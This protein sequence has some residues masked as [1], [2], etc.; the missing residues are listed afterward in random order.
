VKKNIVFWIGVKSTDSNLL[1]KHGNFEYLQYSKYT[2]KYWCD[3]HDIIFFEYSQP[4]DNDTDK[5]RVTWQRWFDVFA[6]VES[7]N[8]EYNKIAVVDGSS[9]IKWDTPNFFNLCSDN[10]VAFRSLENLRWIHEGVQGYKQLFNDFNFDITK[11]ISCG[12]QIFDSSHKEFLLD[13]KKFYYDNLDEILNL[14]KVVARGTDQPVYNYL[15]QMK[16]IKVDS[17]SAPYMLTHMNRFDWFSFNWQ[18]NE[19]QTPFF[20]KYGY[21]WFF[22]GFDRSQRNSLMQQTWNI[23]KQNYQ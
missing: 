13:L 11:Y 15:L 20:I 16:N 14:Q 12:F 19:D 22:S 23:I 8:I 18:L 17:L 10:L 7:L 21:I 9:M 6:Q 3:K 5:H 1:Q 4:T 2:W